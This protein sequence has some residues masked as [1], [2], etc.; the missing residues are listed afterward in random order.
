MF[1]NCLFVVGF[2]ILRVG[3]ER[4]VVLGLGQAGESLGFGVG[5]FFASLFFHSV[6]CRCFFLVQNWVQSLSFA[7]G[8]Q[9]SCV[10]NLGVAGFVALGV[11]PFTLKGIL[12]LFMFCESNWFVCQDDLSR[13]CQW[14][15][16]GRG[17]MKGRNV[18]RHCSYFNGVDIF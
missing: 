1:E 12:N 4:G 10:Y 9:S 13:Y 18:D 16:T 8:L 7:V 17:L 6:I 3:L 14:V 15:T 5:R 11:V 2:L